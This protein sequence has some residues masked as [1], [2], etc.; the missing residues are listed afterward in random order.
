MVLETVGVPSRVVEGSTAKASLLIR[1]SLL[2]GDRSRDWYEMNTV[3]RAGGLHENGRSE[4]R[5]V[6]KECPV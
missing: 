2:N 3:A 6:G 1:L 4:E 5:R